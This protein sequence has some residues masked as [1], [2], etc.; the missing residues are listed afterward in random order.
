MRTAILEPSKAETTSGTRRSSSISSTMRRGSASNVQERT[1]LSAAAAL[2]KAAGSRA[3]GE[4][5]STRMRPSET[6][7]GSMP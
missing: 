6:D 4:V 5:D 1:S 7:R 2:C 3:A